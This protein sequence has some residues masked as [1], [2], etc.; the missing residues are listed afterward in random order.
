MKAGHWPE[1]PDEC[2][3][4]LT[5]NGKISD[6]LLYILGM[7]D[8]AKVDQYVR[9]FF[10]GE[11]VETERLDTLEFAYDDFLGIQF[12]VV[13]SNDYY[14][15]DEEFG[16]WRN[17]SGD[18]SWLHRLVMN[19]R[20][21]TIVGVVQPKPEYGGGVLWSGINYPFSLVLDTIDHA[22][23]SDIVQ[24]QL[25]SPDTD[26]FTNTKFSE[27]GRQKDLNPMSL[28]EVDTDLIWDAIKID[29]GALQSSFLEGADFDSVHVSLPSASF[30]SYLD[31]DEILNSVR[32]QVQNDFPALFAELQFS[33]E[34][35]KEVVLKILSDYIDF[36]E[37]NE[38]LSPEMIIKHLETY[39]SSETFRDLVHQWAENI[40]PDHMTE[41][42]LNEQVNALSALIVQ[43][44]N[45]YL[46]SQQIP[47]LPYFQSCFEEYLQTGRWENIVQEEIKSQ[48]EN[49]D[50]QAVIHYYIE[51]TLQ[52]LVEEQIQNS[53]QQMG[54]D[55]RIQGQVIFNQLKTEIMTCM[56][57][58]FSAALETFPSCISADM[59]L[60]ANA[61]TMR[62]DTQELSDLLLSFTNLSR[63][64]LS[65]NLNRLGYTELSQPKSIC[66]YPKNFECKNEIIAAL[67]HYNQSKEISNE[68]SRT[69][70]YTDTLGTVMGTVTRIITI[71]TGALLTAVAISLIVSS[72]MIGVITYISVLERRKEIGIL[73]A[74]GA[75]KHNI[76][77]IFN[78]E[79]FITGLLS[80]TMGVILGYLLL[81]P[82]NL[83]LHK[84]TGIQDISA[85]LPLEYAAILIVTSIILTIIGG[86]IPSFNASRSD[87]VK[88]LRTE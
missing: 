55:I 61:F 20:D 15:F 14:C 76:A 42:M 31:F 54:N 39:F 56:T 18:T 62:L 26:V 41:E 84:A 48:F 57:N 80:G 1:G 9:D 43:S 49:H 51:T 66:I 52:P 72:I 78:A 83:V 69:V 23:K 77:Q 4:V 30:D 22:G 3:L 16:G 19:G 75:S 33:P 58:G 82:L 50:I 29:K 6:Y 86:I 10:H 74:M 25:S 63:S 8:P 70:S 59:D 53:M 64:S 79:T 7:Q 46:E 45:A 12:K 28:I 67:D 60:L 27:T 2:V 81:T 71:I 11:K 13:D 88:A 44:L 5:N 47:T 85:F 36:L 34:A 32:L 37:E 73:R 17:C 68:K 65:K 24:A 38:Y 40:D 21:L 87:P 35:I